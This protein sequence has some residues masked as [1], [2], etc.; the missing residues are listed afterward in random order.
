MKRSMLLMPDG[1]NSEACIA[2]RAARKTGKTKD[3]G[4]GI[5]HTGLAMRDHGKCNAMAQNMNKSL[6]NA[7][8]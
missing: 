3:S 8:Q 2:S 4:L 1:A 6:A 7:A 5:E